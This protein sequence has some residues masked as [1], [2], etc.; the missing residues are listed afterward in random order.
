M[1][2][3]LPLLPPLVLVFPFSFHELQGQIFYAIFLWHSFEDNSNADMLVC[4]C[5]GGGLWLK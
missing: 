5:V 3:A 2:L 4:V 1:A